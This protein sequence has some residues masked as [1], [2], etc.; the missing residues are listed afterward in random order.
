MQYF[1]TNQKE[2]KIIESTDIFSILWEHFLYANNN[3]NNK[4]EAKPQTADQVTSLRSVLLNDTGA[5]QIIHSRSQTSYNLKSLSSQGTPFTA[6]KTKKELPTGCTN[7]GNKV[8]YLY[9]PNPIIIFL[10]SFFLVFSS[11]LPGLY[12]KSITPVEHSGNPEP[13][14]R[15]KVG[16]DMEKHWLKSC[17]QLSRDTLEVAK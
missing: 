10:G 1:K 16:K 13:L 9:P 7:T 2:S 12:N 14:D 15:L 17:W 11:T 6:G 4:Q 3:D 8:P 5:A